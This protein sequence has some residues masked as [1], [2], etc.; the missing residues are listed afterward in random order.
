MYFAQDWA[1]IKVGVRLLAIYA[2]SLF[3][4]WAATFSQFDPGR[5]NGLTMG[6]ITGV[7]SLLLIYYYWRQETARE[8]W[9]GTAVS[10][11]SS[12]GEQLIPQY[13]LTGRVITYGRG[14]E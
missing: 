14:T 1:D 6:V 7:F 10:L 9:I 11:E 5:R 8:I 12:R 13:V 4:L 2:A 3:I